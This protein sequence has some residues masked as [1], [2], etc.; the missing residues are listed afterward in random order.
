ML[1]GATSIFID[2]A[3]VADPEPVSF[4]LTVKLEL[5]E[6]VGVPEIWPEAPRLN[7]PGSEPELIDHV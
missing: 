5:P 6:V 7:P 4:T 1:T 3:R 2:K